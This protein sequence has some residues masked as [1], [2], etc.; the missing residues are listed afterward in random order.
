MKSYLCHLQSINPEIGNELFE[1]YTL[2]LNNIDFPVFLYDEIEDNDEKID[3]YI[4]NNPLP[5]I[6]DPP[7]K[8]LSNI[9]LTPEI[10]SLKADL[11]TYKDSAS[12]L[13]ISRYIHRGE[14]QDTLQRSEI[15]L[16]KRNRF[17]MLDEDEEID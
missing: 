16:V 7:P 8:W 12:K 14:N 1:L 4:I 13:N 9:T 11:N 5:Q 2:S 3:L 6:Q 15:S 10:D 17:E